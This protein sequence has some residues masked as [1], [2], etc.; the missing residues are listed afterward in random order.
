MQQEPEGPR[1]AVLVAFLGV[2]HVATPRYSCSMLAQRIQD[3]EPGLVLWPADEG[4]WNAA[5]ECGEDAACARRL[6]AAQWPEVCRSILGSIPGEVVAYLEMPDAARAAQDAYELANP[7]GPRSRSYLFASAAL[8]QRQAEVGG[9]SMDWYHSPEYAVLSRQV[10]L[11]LSFASELAMGA[12]GELHVLNR[13]TVAIESLLAQSR[14][15]R[16][17]VLVPPGSR[18][19]VHQALSNDRTWN[20]QPLSP[21]SGQWE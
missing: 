16:V 10:S 6:W 21:L 13:M 20:L 12:G 7:F 3:A 5:I 2:E 17:V 18:Y 14:E 19:Y 11:N 4:T 9:P 8:M 15:R 1:E